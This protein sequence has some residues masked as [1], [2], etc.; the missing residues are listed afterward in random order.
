MCVFPSSSFRPTVAI[1]HVDLRSFSSLLLSPTQLQLD[2]QDPRHPFYILRGFSIT[3]ELGTSHEFSFLFLLLLLLIVC[4]NDLHFHSGPL[5][6]SFYLLDVLYIP[7]VDFEENS[8]LACCALNRWARA[9]VPAPIHGGKKGI[10]IRLPFRFSSRSTQM[11]LHIKAIKGEK[12]SWG[13]RSIHV[14]RSVV[15]DGLSVVVAPHSKVSTIPIRRDINKTSQ[16]REIFTLG[17]GGG[18][19]VCVYAAKTY[20]HTHRVNNTKEGGEKVSGGEGQ[21]GAKKADRFGSL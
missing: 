11:D 9:E 4:R 5:F 7:R 10:W 13:N 3:P 15:C 17:G 6:L 8:R 1:R 12:E 19:C 21:A 14:L 18:G 20:T 2:K 16:S